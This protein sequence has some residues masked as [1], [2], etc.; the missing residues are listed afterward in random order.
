MAWTRSESE[1]Q[2]RRSS[3]ARARVQCFTDRE[4]EAPG[5]EVLAVDTQRVMVRQE[6]SGPK[7]DCMVVSRFWDWLWGFVQDSASLKM[8]HP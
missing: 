8:L 1:C 7:H 5:S 2:A 3:S 4:T 6:Q